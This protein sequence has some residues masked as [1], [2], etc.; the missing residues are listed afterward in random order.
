MGCGEDGADAEEEPTFV[1]VASAGGGGKGKRVS[2]ADVGTSVGEEGIGVPGRDDGDVGGSG[3][4]DGGE[5][6]CG[7]IVET[8]RF[9]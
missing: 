9:L 5:S 6:I 8:G 3:R 7:L 2:A 1:A 4:T